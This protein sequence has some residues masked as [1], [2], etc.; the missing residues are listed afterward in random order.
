MDLETFPLRNFVAREHN[1]RNLILFWRRLFFFFSLSLLYHH[2]LMTICVYFYFTRRISSSFHE[3]CIS[4]LLNFFFFL[5][6]PSWVSIFNIVIL[7][8]L[9]RRGFLI[10]QRIILCYFMR[11]KEKM[12]TWFGG[13][14]V[15]KNSRLN[16]SSFTLSFVSN[17]VQDEPR[18]TSSPL[19]SRLLYLLSR[20]FPPWLLSLLAYL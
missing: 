3:K 19:L 20:Y 17:E 2:F 5:E 8:D 16:F 13:R 10:H 6:K 18:Q 15:L 7:Q 14:I 11:W 9:A 4:N 1:N 12:K